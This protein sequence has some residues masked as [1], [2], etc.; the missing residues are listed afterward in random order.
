MFSFQTNNAIHDWFCYASRGVVH[1]RFV[2]LSLVH[3]CLLFA[4][5]LPH[6][7]P[8]D[9]ELGTIQNQPALTCTIPRVAEVTGSEKSPPGGE[10]APTMVTLPSLLGEPR[11]VTRPARS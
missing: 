10:T 4:A 11:Q 9:A 2:V 7:Q 3:D 6:M 5:W 1:A 8:P